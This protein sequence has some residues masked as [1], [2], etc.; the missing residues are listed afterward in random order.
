[1]LL[2]Y[3]S[4]NLSLW[5]FIS[6]KMSHTSLRHHLPRTMPI[7]LHPYT[8]FPLNIR[9]LRMNCCHSPTSIQGEHI[10][11]VTPALPSPLR[12][13]ISTQTPHQ[14]TSQIPTPV[15]LQNGHPINRSHLRV[16]TPLYTPENTYL[17][18]IRILPSLQNAN[19]QNRLLVHV[20]IF[21]RTWIFPSQ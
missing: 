19:P 4:K 11:P 5:M 13:P 6:E 8:L 20:T 1:M 18:M 16:Q 7:L 2:S 14:Y 10:R 21:K 9:Y 15:S 3:L 17:T 12:Q